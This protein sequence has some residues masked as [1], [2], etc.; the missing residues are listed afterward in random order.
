MYTF[1]L[2]NNNKPDLDIVV[3]R[4]MFAIV[5]AAAF[6]Q[7]AD[8]GAVAIGAGVFFIIIA[9]FLRSIMNYFR[10][11]VLVMLIMAI[12]LMCLVTKSPYFALI[13]I[14]HWLLVKYRSR[15]S[16]VDID[17]GGV[18]IV[19]F[20]NDRLYPWAV[21]QNVVLKDGLLTIDFSNNKISQSPVTPKD[22][23]LDEK[24]FNQFCRQQLP[25]YPN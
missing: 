7:Y 2:V 12:V 16:R 11:P 8:Y 25:Q 24:S 4:A 20:L 14:L 3:T 5:T 9:F 13:L 19:S 10:I 1:Y 15:P 22:T 21:L 17:P 6:A 23:T 18:R